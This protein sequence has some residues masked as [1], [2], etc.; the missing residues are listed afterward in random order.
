MN[1]PGGANAFSI[2]PDSTNRSSVS[3]ALGAA[4]AFSLQSLVDSYTHNVEEESAG[5]PL[6]PMVAP[7]QNASAG[8]SIFNTPSPPAR[9]S[10]QHVDVDDPELVGTERISNA[11]QS[12]WQ[13]R[14]NDLVAFRKEYGNCCVPT[15]WPQNPPLAQW[16]KRQ[17]YQYKLKLQEKHS[18]MTDKRLEALNC[19]GMVWDPQAAFWEERLAEL[20]QFRETYGHCNVPTKFPDHP[21]LAIWVKCQ[22]R[23]FKIFCTHGP[24]KS[25]ITTERIAKLQKIGFVFS[26]REAKKHNCAKKRLAC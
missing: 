20:M 11:Q 19:L 10:L 17:R 9:A 2:T 5:E 16:V 12:R 15:H 26:P 13:E 7:Q 14:F 1:N 8:I 23:Q 21:E 3:G 18:T 22:R 24:K 25:N 4:R 6:L